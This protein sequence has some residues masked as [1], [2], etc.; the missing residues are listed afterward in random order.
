MAQAWR[1]KIRNIHKGWWWALGGF[2]AYTLAGFLLAPGLLEKVLSD[3]VSEKLH[4]QARVKELRINPLALSVELKDFTIHDGPRQLIGLE[5]LYLNVDATSL[6]RWAIAMDEVHL[7]KPYVNAVLAANGELNLLKLVP[8]DDKE[9]SP[10]IRWL[11]HDFKLNGGAIDFTDEG[12]KPALKSRMEPLNLA[13]QEISSL[14]DRSGGYQLVAE[15]GRGGRFAWKGE[16][17]LKPLKSRGHITIEGIDLPFFSQLSPTPLPVTVKAGVLGLS[18]DYRLETGKGPLSVR[19]EQGTATLKD[20]ELAA[21]GPQADR[22][23]KLPVLQVSGIAMRYPEQLASVAEVRLTGG[24][25]EVVREASGQLNWLKAINSVPPAKP[26]KPATT[27]EAPAKPWTASLE[28][29]VL[30]KFTVHARDEGV[31][32]AF[33]TEIRDIELRLKGLSQNLQ[34]SIDVELDAAIGESGKIHVAGDAIPGSPRFEG[35]IDLQGL[36]LAPLQTYIKDVAQIELKSGALA[37]QGRLRFSP[38]EKPSM[39]YSGTAEVTQ[40]LVHDQKMDERLLSFDRLAFRN[41]DFRQVPDRLSI[42]QIHAGSLFGRVIINADRTVNLGTLAVDAKTPAA[43][44]GAPA[45]PFPVRIG[46]VSFSDSSLAFADMSMRPEFATG[47]E[48]LK[49]EITG[50]NSEEITRANIKLEGRVD[51]YGKAAI[52]G[53]INPLAKDLFAD[54]GVNFKNVELTTLTPY[55][56]KFAGYRIDKGQLNLDLHYNIVKRALKAENKVVLNQLTLGDKVDSPDAMHLP[57]KLAL[58]LLKDSH[59][60]IDIDLPITGSLD[61]PEFK[62]GRVLWKAFVNLLTKA[63]TAPFRMLADLAGGNEEEMKSVLFPLGNATLPDTEIAKLEKIAK[64]LAQR[65]ALSLE[66]R[67]LADSRHDALSIR[68]QRFNEAARQRGLPSVAGKE[69]RRAMESWLTEQAGKDAV[70]G[71]RALAMI[72]A[73][74]Q[75]SS[76]KPDL[77]LNENAYD[78]KLRNGLIDRMP[79]GETEIRALALDRSR[80]VKSILVE[81]FQMDEGR[82]FVMDADEDTANGEV[83]GTTLNVVAK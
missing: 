6:F 83:I 19:L 42:Q 35:D 74:G 62:Y 70:A 64:A 63:A 18:T 24:E 31:K 77:I 61:D 58:A 45:K 2:I 23:L 22:L 56:A 65:P 10:E 73:P 38:A 75:E 27:A 60:V 72:P 26:S 7:D 57:L 9:P 20:L 47:I 49:G 37:T 54:I 34:Q 3:K 52:S 32:P 13:L 25:L 17:G 55:S 33:A 12:K 78:E 71:L 14:P 1:E 29:L 41:I 48:K 81:K 43:K 15:S 51:R 8:P 4:L 53:Q 79:F 46:K 39:T 67:G 30:E 68:T 11:I 50:L 59:G 76:P 36:A 80:L 82:I 5:R 69:R 66:V 28:Q 16:L 44:S 21:N 40:V